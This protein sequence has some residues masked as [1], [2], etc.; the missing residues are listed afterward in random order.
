MAFLLPVDPVA[1]KNQRGTKRGATA[2]EISATDLKQSR[3]PKT[4]VEIRYYTTE[5]YRRSSQL[6]S[7]LNF[8]SYANPSVARLEGL[9]RQRGPRWYPRGHAPVRGE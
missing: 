6:M 5:E 1:K 9:R 3:G 4:G 7:K 8:G 2:A